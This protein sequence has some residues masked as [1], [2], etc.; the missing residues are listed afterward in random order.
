MHTIKKQQAHAGQTTVRRWAALL[1]VCLQT[2][3]EHPCRA[4]SFHPVC[5][6]THQTLMFCILGWQAG[7]AGPHSCIGL[8]SSPSTTFLRSNDGAKP[9]ARQTAL[10]FLSRS[11]IL[12][13]SFKTFIYIAST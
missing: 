11:C 13:H 12:H 1:L 5:Q 3:S 7:S 10:L 9:P 6:Q 2:C 8:A 4:L